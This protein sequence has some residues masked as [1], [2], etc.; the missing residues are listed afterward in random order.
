MES[1]GHGISDVLRILATKG[2]HETLLYIRDNED[3][4]YNAVLD[5]V[6]CNKIVASRAS[7]HKTITK[8]TDIGLLERRITQDRPV[9]MG[10][11]VSEKGRRVIK[12]LD[13]IGQATKC[14]GCGPGCSSV[15][16]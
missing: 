4:G 12:Y 3:V 15:R 2:T 11:R 13:E 16:P 1:D 10:Y 8:L 7:M 14:D 5:Y 9:R 6:I